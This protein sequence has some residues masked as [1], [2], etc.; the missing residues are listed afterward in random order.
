MRVLHLPHNIASIPSHTIRGLRAIGVEARGLVIGGNIH[1]SSDGLKVVTLSGCSR[2]ERKGK[3]LL[4]WWNFL[5]WIWW[6]DVIHWY[7]SELL[8]SGLDLKIVRLLGKPA[9]VEWLG[10]EIRIPE[11][12]IRDNPYYETA[13]HDKGFEC[14]RESLEGSRARQ[15][16]FIDA[17]FVPIV[18]GTTGTI[19]YIQ[20]DICPRFFS[21]SQRLSLSDFE[22]AYPHPDN[23]RP[24]VVHSPSAPVTKGTPYVLAAVE[25]LKRTCDFDFLLLQDMPRHEVLESVKKADIYL[26]QFVLGLYGMAGLEAMAFGKP[27]VCYMKPSLLDKF[28]PDIPVVNASPEELEEK[29]EMLLRDGRLRYETGRRSRN[30]VETYHDSVEIAGQLVEIYRNVME[31]RA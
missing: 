21:L 30:Y 27:V 12:E 24:L 14:A 20:T 7:F 26:D 29:L 13:Y 6:A 15:K 11:I 5:R 8:P 25:R 3:K 1:Q 19:Q 10:S 16:L 2:L 23:P 4:F 28:S 9:V 18:S 31:Q 17:G 22:P